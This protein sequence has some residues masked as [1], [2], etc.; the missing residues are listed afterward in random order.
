MLKGIWD[1]WMATWSG[2]PEFMRISGSLSQE[3]P[4]SSNE[5]T[6]LSLSFKSSSWHRSVTTEPSLCWISF[7]SSNLFCSRVTKAD[8]NHHG[9]QRLQTDSLVGNPITFF[10]SPGDQIPTLYL[11]LLSL[12]YQIFWNPTL[13]L[14]KKIPGGHACRNGDGHPPSSLQFQM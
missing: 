10:D 8:S 13:H 3:K 5:M 2:P 9:N 14:A 4:I 11:Q 1:R 7:S 12:P 6:I